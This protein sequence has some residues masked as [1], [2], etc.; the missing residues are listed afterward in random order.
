MVQEWVKAQLNTVHSDEVRKLVH[1]RTKI[2]TE[3]QGD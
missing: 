3:K 1:T 2:H